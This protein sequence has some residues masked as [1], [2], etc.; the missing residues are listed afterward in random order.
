MKFRLGWRNNNVSACSEGAIARSRATS[1]KPV[2][3]SIPLFGSVF[4]LFCTLGCY[5]APSAWAS[6]RLIV[7]AGLFQHSV[8]IESLEHLAKTGEV[9]PPLKPYEFLL[10][11]NIKQAFSKRL[12]VDPALVE[13]FLAD[14]FSSPDGE[15]LLDQLSKALP[16]SDAQRIKDT[17]SQALHG[18]DVL[19]FL[20]FVRAYPDANLTVDLAAV[21]KIAVQLNASSWQNQLMSPRLER[22]LKVETNESIP[23]SLDPTALGNETVSMVTLRLRDRTRQ[24]NIPVDIYYSSNTR[25]PLVVISHGFAAD[26]KFLRYLAR[27]LASHGL[28]V[29]ALDHPGSNIAVL[30]KKAMGTRVS[31]LLPASEFVDR[32]QDI[33]FL[34]DRLEILNR[35]K[36]LL[37]GKFNLRQVTVI[38]HSYG[39]YTALAVA[40]A[41]LNPKALRSFCQAVTPLQRSPADWLQCAAAELPYGKRQFRDPR[42]AQVIAF[43]PIIGNLFGNDLSGVKVP[44]L[45]VSS[46]ADG[47]TPTISHQLR[48]FQQLSGEKYLLVAIGATHMS[49][50]DIGNLNSTVGQS[51]LVQEVMGKEAES[52]RQMA[53]AIAFAFVEQLTP[54]AQTYRPFLSPAYVQSLSDDKIT[55]RLA[56]ELPPTIEAWLNVLNLGNRYTDSDEFEDKPSILKAIKGYFVNA[57]EMISPPGY[58]TGQLDRL[59]TG[60]LNTYDSDRHYWDSLA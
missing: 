33:S 50:T 7:R 28:T 51:T 34:L 52:M 19:S 20:S 60:L 55:F 40:G 11:P 48:P 1:Q 16:G 38:G 41:E 24:R 32:P 31:Q 47:I 18:G 49:V 44:T 45:I 23:R 6:E 10:T 37:Q 35:R 4:T 27:H 17:F 59:F 14:L 12:H 8:E 57:R 29:A 9:P 42:V 22:D 13:P 39:S 46:S 26:R 58:C 2:R 21:A 54:T 36:G 56:K 25:G 30:V 43:N 15:K 53:K 5:V 3:S